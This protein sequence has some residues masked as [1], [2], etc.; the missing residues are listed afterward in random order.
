[1][2]SASIRYVNA[3]RRKVNIKGL[4]LKILILVVVFLHSNNTGCTV[5]FEITNVSTTGDVLSSYQSE[6]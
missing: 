4:I 6:T 1:M 3:T 5:V 2:K